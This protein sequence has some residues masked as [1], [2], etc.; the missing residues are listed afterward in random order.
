MDD[1]KPRSA[2]GTRFANRSECFGSTQAGVRISIITAVY[3]GMPCLEE[4]I[5]SVLA[6]GSSEV[7]HVVIDGG[8]TDGTVDLLDR[9]SDRIAYWHSR[10]DSGIYDAWNSGLAEAKGEWI[11]FLGADDRLCNG[12]IEA[13]LSY[14][15]ENELRKWDLISSKS[16][17]L[18]PDQRSFSISGREWAWPEFSKHMCIAHPAALHHRRLF[19]RFGGFDTSY[20]ICGDYEFLLRAGSSLRAGFLDRVTA[21]CKAGGVSETARAPIEAARAKYRTGGRALLL[22]WV[23]CFYF[24]LRSAINSTRLGPWIRELRLALNGDK[25][26]VGRM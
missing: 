16:Q 17:R 4:A 14:I 19:Q 5:N 21:I 1:R 9:Y 25:G 15:E 26:D 10:S 18:S 2:G 23:E 13:Y 3:N 24:L 8:S 6:Q 12:A 7:E 11:A 22:C 20:R